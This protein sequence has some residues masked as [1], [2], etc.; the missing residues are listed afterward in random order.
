MIHLGAIVLVTRNKIILHE[1]QRRF[2]QALRDNA[3]ANDP[4]STSRLLTE[5]RFTPFRLSHQPK[6]PCYQF[7]VDSARG[8]YYDHSVLNMFTRFDP[9]Y[10]RAQR[11]GIFIS[12]FLGNLFAESFF[13][14][15][16]DGVDDVTLGFTIAA[17]VAA[18]FAVALPVK[19]TIKVLFRVTQARSGSTMDRVMQIFRVSAFNNNISPASATDAER[20]D[21]AVSIS[22]SPSTHIRQDTFFLTVAVCFLSCADA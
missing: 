16:K 12:M 1:R 9:F 21:V 17:T 14:A 4:F 8:L 22:L 6:V 5:N 10:N 15:L 13:Y 19:L 7:F 20:A 11:W 2:L 18:S 3:K